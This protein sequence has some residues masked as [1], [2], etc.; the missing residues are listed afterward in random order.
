MRQAFKRSTVFIGCSAVTLLSACG[1]G[2]ATSSPPSIDAAAN[3]AGYETAGAHRQYG[4]PVTI[5]DGKVRTYVVLDGKR[6]QMPLEIGVALDER[7]LN[8]LPSDMRMLY[9][10][11]PAQ[12]PAPYNFVLFDWNPNGHEPDMV[13]TLPHFDFHFYA[14]PE[15][16]VTS[17]VPGPTFAADASAL[18][19]DVPPFYIVPGPPPLQAVPNMGVHW[20]DVRSPELQKL[21]PINHPALW[22]EFTTTFIYGS[23]KGKFTFLEP[24]VTT[25]FLRSQPDTLMVISTPNNA[26]SPAAFGK[27]GWYPSAYRVVYDA[28]AKEYR[29][30]LA[31]LAWRQ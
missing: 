14:V 2:S 16:E 17:I 27:A 5:G 29:V 26:A 8:S 31:A 30:G 18:P 4:V 20:L 25:A 11:L 24:M 1:D 12:A 22:K 19:T 9:L 21:P 23:W 7:A 15:A 10:P 28:Q 6:G 13:Y 3:R